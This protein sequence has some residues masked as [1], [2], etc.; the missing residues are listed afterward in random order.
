[1]ITLASSRATSARITSPRGASAAPSWKIT[2]HTDA[3]V[4]R[5]SSVSFER[6]G[7]ATMRR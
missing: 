4:L 3:E 2:L 7:G 1:M 5:S 6:S